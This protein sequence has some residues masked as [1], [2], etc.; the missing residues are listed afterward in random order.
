MGA[1]GGPAQ[2]VA[3]W[4]TSGTRCLSGVWRM[5][6]RRRALLTHLELFSHSRLAEEGQ[7]HE[8]DV[9]DLSGLCWILFIGFSTCYFHGR[10]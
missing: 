10:S 1:T 9:P 8:A 5:Q 3:A 6:R 2:P 4:K 7:S